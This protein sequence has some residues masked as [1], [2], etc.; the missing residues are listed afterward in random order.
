MKAEIRSIKKIVDEIGFVGQNLISINDLTNEQLYKLFEFAHVL[1][2]WNRTK[3]DF[4]SE[5]LMTLLFFQPS[6]RTRM[7][8]ET[9]MKRLGGMVIT[10]TSPLVS[11]SAAKEESLNDTMKVIS[12]YSNLIVLRHPDDK[13]AIEAVSYA[14]CPVI[15]GGFGHYEHPTQS[16]TDLYT[17]WRIYGKI[18]G[19]KIC[20]ASPD[21][22]HART[23]HSMAY[24]LARLGADLSV[25]SLKEHRMPEAVMQKVK[26]FNSKTKE[27]FDQSQDEFNN[28]VSGMDMVYLPGCSAP[29]GAD[30]EAFKKIMDNYFIRFETVDAKFQEGGKLYVTHTLPRRQ[31]EMDLRLDKSP[32]EIYFKAISHSISIRMALV[33]AIVGV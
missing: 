24:A 1:E 7:S 8:F 6:T 9:A 21:M 28:Y 23:G 33:A 22:V 12:K 20:I 14:D 31:G 13:E 5:N 11:S 10:E 19:L 26:K 27:I 18:E 3:L 29:K 2:P 17:L 25:V 4:L 16:L 30:S 15:S 32:G